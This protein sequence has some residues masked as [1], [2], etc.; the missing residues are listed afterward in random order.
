MH[1]QNEIHIIG[2]TSRR[3]IDEGPKKRVDSGIPCDKSSIPKCALSGA[4]H[5]DLFPLISLPMRFFGR[6]LKGRAQS[7]LA[8][9]RRYLWIVPDLAPRGTVDAQKGYAFSPGT[10]NR[11][12]PGHRF[13]ICLFA[14]HLQPLTLF[15]LQT[16]GYS[17]GFT[18]GITE[19]VKERRA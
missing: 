16:A 3:K 8:F 5:T 1:L 4:P 6:H 18:G 17:T 7:I 2:P 10:G 11:T 14:R 15:R 13:I 9:Q 12:L 19:D